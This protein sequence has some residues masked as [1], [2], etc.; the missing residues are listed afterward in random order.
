MKRKIDGKLS[1]WILSSPQREAENIHKSLLIQGL[2]QVGKSYSIRESLSLPVD[3]PTVIISYPR[4]AGWPET[5]A[6]EVNLSI[7]ESFIEAFSGSS[8]AMD[9]IKKLNQDP[10]FN[11]CN[12]V[13]DNN[14][15]VIL[16]I[17]EIQESPQALKALKFLSFQK[18]LV[19]IASGSLLGVSIKGE[20][21]FPTGYVDIVRMYP[22][23]FEE[24]LWA[25]GFTEKNID[26]FL[27]EIRANRP[28][29]TSLH[30]KL[31]SL[32]REYIVSG[33]LPENVDIA[34]REGISSP[35]LFINQR[36]LLHAYESDIGKYAPKEERI[37]AQQ[38]FQA[39]PNALAR[40]NT[41]FTYSLLGRGASS[42]RYEGALAWLINAGLVYQVNNLEEPLRPLKAK[43]I[44]NDF[45]L[46]L[47]DPGILWAMIG[48]QNALNILDPSNEFQK[49]MIY[50]NST[51]D[52]LKMS[53]VFDDRDVYYY[54]RNSTLEVDFLI[55]TESKAVIVEAKSSL[56]T[57][58]K[59]VS[60]LMKE[61]P[62]LYAVKVSPKNVGNV[63]HLYSLP[64]YCLCFIDRL[65]G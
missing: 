7:N 1:E 9:I 46:Y 60:T 41:R 28:L 29:L 27:E 30:E 17:D 52:I 38:V 21:F 64:H 45:K 50:E 26:D 18:N 63:A 36:A 44:V 24:F 10:A 15:C 33:G 61:Y 32:Y 34:I 5:I 2:R 54:E 37:K 35:K 31:M 39:I 16:F 59:S 43:A 25:H 65:L 53:L 58:S 51:A 20:D 3:D 11:K 14:H 47:S 56:N 55:E 49:G 23:D 8:N 22:M 42:S 57:K 62:S 4:F 13:P 40:T 12:L 6:I 48:N 19:V